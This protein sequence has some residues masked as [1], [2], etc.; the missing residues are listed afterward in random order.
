M[1]LP[2]PG[3]RGV[4]RYPGLGADFGR[5][6]PHARPL[7]CRHDLLNLES[8]ALHLNLTLLF[9]ERV[10]KFLLDE[11]DTAESLIFLAEM[12]GP[13]IEGVKYRIQPGG[14]TFKRDRS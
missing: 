8:L 10:S 4:L 13:Q 6:N 2:V 14:R 11:A 9:E 1:L 12:K 5:R 3:V 7:H